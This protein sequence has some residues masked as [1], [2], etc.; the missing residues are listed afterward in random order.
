MAATETATVQAT[1]P[2]T[3][4]ATATETTTVAAATLAAAPAIT[5]TA[6]LTAT[7]T[8][9]RPA[10]TPAPSGQIAFPRYDPARQTYDVHVCRLDLSGRVQDSACRRVV[11]LASQPDFLPGGGQLVVHS[12]QPDAKGLAI[13]N[14]DG[15]LVW[16]I[17]DQIEAARPS[18]DFE[19]KH[20]VYYS[21]QEL[22]R[23]P[24]LY[25]TYEAEYAAFERAGS[26]VPGHA[27][28]W[29]PGGQILYSGCLGDDCGILL[30]NGDGS[31][32]QQVIP[33]GSETN[34]EASADGRRIAFMS[35]KDGNW[36]IYVARADGSK[37]QRITRDPGNDGLPAWSPDGRYLAFV[38]DRDGTW[39]VWVVRADGSSLARLFTIGGSL[40][41]PVQGA[42]AHEVHG[43]LEE[44]ISWAPLP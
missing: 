1:A 17:T 22:D 39:A 9:T 32:P 29:T 23:E 43:W 3:Q 36:E 24:R 8:A 20:Y 18:V 42:A 30:M 41:G 31:H 10:P 11:A 14:L 33:G 34:P 35:N 38:S 40:E 12:W 21:R 16:H 26:P 2:P 28:A 19:G 27:P 7:V 37:V 13:H 44:R 25:R 4:A 5:T 6:T 15:H